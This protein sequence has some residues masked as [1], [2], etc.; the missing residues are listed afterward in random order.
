MCVT[1]KG[2]DHMGISQFNE[3]DLVKRLRIG[4]IVGE[5]AVGQLVLF[6]ILLRAFCTFSW[7]KGPR[8]TNVA[9]L[10]W[11]S[12]TA[13]WGKGNSNLMA[14]M[15]NICSAHAASPFLVDCI[16]KQRAFLHRG[17]DY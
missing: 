6:L 4:V 3:Q 13:Q 5:V 9:S 1:E 12:L 7:D 15:A 16:G 2:Q 10:A 11:L 8:L 17:R 14:H